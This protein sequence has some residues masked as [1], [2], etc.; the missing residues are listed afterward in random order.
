[1]YHKDIRAPWFDPQVVQNLIFTPMSFHIITRTTVAQKNSIALIFYS[2]MNKVTSLK[3]TTQIKSNTQVNFIYLNF[4][5]LDAPPPHLP[6]IIR[7]R[8]GSIMC[9]GVV[10]LCTFS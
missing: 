7:V 8:K 3:L 4:N 2:R 6:D 1:M 5:Y 9:Y 10:R